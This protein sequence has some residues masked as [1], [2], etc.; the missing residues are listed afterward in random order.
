VLILAT[1]TA[2]ESPML[3]RTAKLRATTLV[4]V[5]IAS[6]FDWSEARWVMS[7]SVAR[8]FIAVVGWLT[9][10]DAIS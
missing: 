6:E 2:S 3:R 10:I 1:L 7:P 4:L 9:C 5:A 8:V